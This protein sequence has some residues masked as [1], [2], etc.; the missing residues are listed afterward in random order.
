MVTIGTY[1]YSDFFDRQFGLLTPWSHVPHLALS[2]TDD[3]TFMQRWYNTALST[4]DWIIRQLMYLPGQNAL[5]EKHFAHLE[6]L[7]SIQEL[8]KN[9]SLILINTHRSMLIPRPSMPGIVHIGGAHI[10]KPNPL[11]SHIQQFLDESPNG[12]IYFSFG[13][14]VKASK[15]PKEKI[16]AFLGNFSK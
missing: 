12:V 3:M 6:P 11:P 4:F 8:Q 16:N 1:G 10:K 9:V 13:T 15:L 14:V 7:P 5:A 2:F